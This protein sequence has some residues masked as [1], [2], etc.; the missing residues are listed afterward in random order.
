MKHISSFEA[1]GRMH[2]TC[3]FN[4]RDDSDAFLA[5]MEKKTCPTNFAVYMDGFMDGKL[6]QHKRK[7]RFAKAFADKPAAEWKT[8][9]L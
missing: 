8:E 3:F 4:E 7:F 9:E 5:M 2:G 6:G 1:L